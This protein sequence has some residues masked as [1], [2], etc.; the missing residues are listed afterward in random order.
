[1]K[2]L[3]LIGMLVVAVALFYGVR[4]LFTFRP[5]QT[6]ATASPVPSTPQPEIPPVAVQPVA[7][8]ATK[9]KPKA[10]AKAKRSKK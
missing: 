8:P 4:Y 2:L 7:M 1:M 10:K 5:P 3:A 9:A 6:P